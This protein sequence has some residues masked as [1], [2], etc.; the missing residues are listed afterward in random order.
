ML[1]AIFVDLTAKT[2]PYF[3]EYRSRI[4]ELDGYKCIQFTIYNRENNTI[5]DGMLLIEGIKK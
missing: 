2:E 5:T 1:I 3:P 4:V